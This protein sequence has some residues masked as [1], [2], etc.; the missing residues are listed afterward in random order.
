M[1]EW[2][3][4]QVVTGKEQKT[5]EL[6]RKIVDKSILNDC[7]IPK[8]ERMKRYQG[9]W[10]KEEYVMFP[11]YVF[12]IT[13]RVQELYYELKAVPEFTKI[14]GADKEMISIETKE[15]DLLRRMENQDHLVEMSQGYIVGD[16][17]VIT[18]GPL[19]DIDGKI[20]KIDRHKRVAELEVAMFG[21]IVRVKVGIEIVEKRE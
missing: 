19:K 18:S 7:F 21:R 12:L 6:C 10:H 14:L 8:C 13:G 1:E 17:V 4:V 15:A 3:A 20:R 11:G 9:E 2:Y 16:Q 5:V